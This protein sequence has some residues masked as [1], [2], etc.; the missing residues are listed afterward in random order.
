MSALTLPDIPHSGNGKGRMVIFFLSP[1]V[2]DFDTYLPVAM[3]M[4]AARPDWDI[5]F[6]T[7]STENYD[8]IGKNPTLM[9]G[10]HRCGRLQCFSSAGPGGFIGRTLRRLMSL[11]SLVFMIVRRPKPILFQARPFAQMP[12]SLFY[13]LSRLR[14]GVAFLLWKNRS[15]DVV[16]HIVW[17]NREKPAQHQSSFLNRLIGRDIDGLIYYHREQKDNVSLSGRYGRIENVPWHSIGLPHLFPRWREL[18][19]DEVAAAHRDLEKEGFP[20]DTEIYCFFAAKPFSSVNLRT[21]QSVEETF[22]LCLKTL[23][24]LRPDALVLIRPHPLAVD[25]VHIKAGIEIVG[26]K[27]ARISFI[28]PEVLIALSRRA[29]CDNPTN[30]IFSCFPGKI[31][32]CSD[33]P[34]SHY[35]EFGQVSLAHGYGPVFVNPVAVDFKKQFASALEDSAFDNLALHSLKYE[36]LADSEPDLTPVL[37]MVG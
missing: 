26:S 24:D 28:H 12:Y 5:R 37:E 19:D 16:H 18:I 1:R 7:F 14:G 23:C 27:R 3:E 2:I 36:L 4:K 34:D 17:Q 10:L 20:A 22:A 35:A 9:A 25:A 33:Y 31:I 11:F 13:A 6:V 8:I 21:A 32:D 29:I 30:I 15:P